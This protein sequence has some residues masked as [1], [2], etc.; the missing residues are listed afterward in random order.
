MKMAIAR[1][2][3][4]LSG[5]KMAIARSDPDLSDRDLSGVMSDALFVMLM[6]S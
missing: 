1:S 4:D 3:T 5:V 2:D 6:L